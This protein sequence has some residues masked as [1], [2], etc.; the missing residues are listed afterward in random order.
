MTIFESDESGRL[1][2]KKKVA[3]GRLVSVTDPEARHGR[4][5]RRRLFNGFKI[6]IVG[7]I[8]SGL[9]A[10][11]TVTQGSAHDAAPAHRLISRAKGLFD[12]IERVLADTAYGAVRLRHVVERTLAVEML[13]PPPP[14]TAPKRTG[15]KKAMTFDFE[16]GTVTCANGVT[17]GDFSVVMHREYGVPARRYRWPKEVC[18]ACPLRADCRNG[19]RGGHTLLLHPNEQELQEVRERWQHPEVREDYRVRSQC[20]RLV[21]QVT[22]HGGR[23]ARAWGLG[24]ANLQ[25]HLIAL[26]CNLKIL[27]EALEAREEEQR[28]QAA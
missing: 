5:T 4:K 24:A 27:A 13:A 3:K 14:D 25:A 9:I 12:E 10:A 8:V 19:R 7:D 18:Q 2:V 23:R 15:G 6:H 17:T 16:H 28:A 22:R 21:N 20:E 11:I 26:R 1:V